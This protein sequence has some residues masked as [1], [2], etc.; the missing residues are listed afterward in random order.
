MFKVSTSKRRLYDHSDLKDAYLSVPIHKDSQKFLQFLWRNKCYAFQG[1]C[2]GLNTAPRIFTKLLKPVAPFLRKRDVRIILYL[3]DFLILGSTYQ[4]AQIHAAMAV[5]LLGSLGFTVNL[6]TDPNNNIPGLCN[7]LH[8]RSTKPPIGESSKGEIPLLEDK[9]NSNFTCSSNSKCTR[10]SRVVSPSN[11]ASS[12]H[13]WC[14]QIRMIQALRSSNEN[15]DV[16][17]TLDHDSLEELHWWVSNIIIV[18][19][20]RTNQSKIFRPLSI[21]VHTTL[22]ASMGRAIPFSARALEKKKHF[23][24]RWYCGKKQIE[25]W[26]IVVLTCVAGGISRV[27][28]FV[29]VAKPWTRVAKPWEDWWRVQLNSRL[30]KFVGFFELC[31]HQWTRISDWLRVPKRQSSVNLY[32]S[33]FPGEKVCFHT[34][35]CNGQ[36]EEMQRGSFEFPEY[37]LEEQKNYANGRTGKGR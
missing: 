34:Q 19:M 37:P 3:D 33:S 21:R 8:C 6:E 1:L 23:L 16:L 32:L 24:W 10:H 30:P 26:F 4:E 12:P 28:A 25:M 11:L 17:T 9:G 15:F 35:I 27:R 31:V 13:F 29:L 36:C 2:F 20:L 7:R 14:L 22:L 18:R 5:S